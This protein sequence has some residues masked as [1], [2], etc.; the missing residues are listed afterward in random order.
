[1]WIAVTVL[2]GLGICIGYM[3]GYRQGE[4]DMRAK[5]VKDNVI[6]IFTRRKIR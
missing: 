2:I 6:D 4:S 5:L 1:M 3:L